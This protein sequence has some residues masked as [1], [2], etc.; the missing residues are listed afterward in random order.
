MT[1]TAAASSTQR[2][3]RLAAVSGRRRCAGS[4]VRRT[5]VSPNSRSCGSTN[6]T[7]NTVM[8]DPTPTNRPMPATAPDETRAPMSRPAEMSI[9]PEVMMVGKARFSAVIMA[10][11]GPCS[12]R[13]SV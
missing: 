12:L 3:A 11:R 7:R 10:S 2:A 5:K 6:S 9:V 13:A 1:N 8:S 4:A